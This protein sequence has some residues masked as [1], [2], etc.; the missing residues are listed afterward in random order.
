[1]L[2]LIPNGVAGVVAVTCIVLAVLITGAVV[3]AAALSRK[4]VPGQQAEDRKVVSPPQQHGITPGM[5]R[6]GS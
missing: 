5:P 4:I 3:I 1:M 2:S 6:T